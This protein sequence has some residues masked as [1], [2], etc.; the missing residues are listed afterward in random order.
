MEKNLLRQ[1]QRIGTDLN[2]I[3]RIYFYSVPII[4]LTI[5]ST[6][7]VFSHIIQFRKF[8][9]SKTNIGL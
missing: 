7:I 2:I 6:H 9:F 5:Y 1:I 3:K 4:S 8:G